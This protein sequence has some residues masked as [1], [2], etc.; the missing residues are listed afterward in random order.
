MDAMESMES[1]DSMESME[2]METVKRHYTCDGLVHVHTNVCFAA[3]INAFAALR[4]PLQPHGDLVDPIDG[5]R[6]CVSVAEQNSVKY[7]NHKKS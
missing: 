4:A 1:M 7:R 2:S 6:S 5:E 3:Q